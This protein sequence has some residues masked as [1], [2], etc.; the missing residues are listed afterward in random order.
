MH[1]TESNLRGHLWPIAAVFLTCWIIAHNGNLSDRTL[2]HAQ[3]DPKRFP[4]A[5]VDYIS[6]ANLKGPIF[7]PDQW[8]GYLIYRLYPQAKVVLDDRHDF[9]GESFLKSYLKLIHLEPGWEEF[10]HDHPANCLVLPRESALANILAETD[11]W[12]AIYRDDVAVIFV[13]ESTSGGS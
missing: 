5:A 12:R 13:P 10:L 6:K 4:V 2:I 3:F 8:G 1:T 11:N 7:A 9:Y